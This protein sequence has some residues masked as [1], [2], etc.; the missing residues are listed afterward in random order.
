MSSV[1][2]AAEIRQ[3]ILALVGEYSDLALAPKAFQPGSS[4]IPPSG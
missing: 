2:R 3:N 4:V 1:G